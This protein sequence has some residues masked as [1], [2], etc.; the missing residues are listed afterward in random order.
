MPIAR[1]DVTSVLERLGL[2]PA[3]LVVR[4]ESLGDNCEFGEVQRYFGT[5]PLGLFRWSNPSAEAILHGLDTDFADLGRNARVELNTEP[6]PEWLLVEPDYDL[7][8]HTHIREGELP[9]ETVER[10]QLGRF[11]FLRRKLLE[12]IEQANK[13]FVVKAQPDVPLETAARIARALRRKGPA[14][15]LWVVVDARPGRVEIV[16]DGLL[17]GGIDYLLRTAFN[18][19]SF[20][21]WLTLLANALALVGAL[22]DAR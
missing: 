17:R 21:M 14:W 9:R 10:Q 19:A 13:I 16:G 12:D 20:D 8:Q 5:E 18:G 1:D 11:Q 6:W 22:D 3:E 15:L 4:F 2:S 7:V